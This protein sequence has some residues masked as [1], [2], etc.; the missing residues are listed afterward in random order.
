MTAEWR[1]RRRAILLV[2]L[3]VLVDRATKIWI[4]DLLLDTQTRRI[5]VTGFFN[6]VMVWN[7][8]ISFG[9]F[10]GSGLGPLPFLIIAAVVVF[11]LL[12]WLWQTDSLLIAIPLGMVIGG[13]LG[14]GWDR[15]RYGAVFDFVDLHALGWHFW[16]FNV[17]DAA[18]SLGVLVLLYDALFPPRTGDK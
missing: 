7:P 6:L 1:V 8:G 3:I 9:M 11:I 4:L 18:I 17:A 15:L 2:A 10:A 5:E 13:A 12:R 16:A 14:N